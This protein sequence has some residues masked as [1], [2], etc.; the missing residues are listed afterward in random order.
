MA[1]VVVALFI[2]RS[3][4]QPGPQAD[5]SAATT[6]APGADPAAAEINAG[7]AA[8][9]PNQAV[10]HFK[11]ALEINPQHYGA[12]FQ[13]ARAL[14]KAGRKDEALAQWRQVLA[15]AEQSNDQPLVE[16]ARTRIAQ[17]SGGQ[18]PAAAGDPMAA[19]LEA[20]YGRKDPATA[21]A[22]FREVLGQNPDHYGATYQLATAL[23]QAGD[24]RGARPVWQKMLQMAEATQDAQTAEAARA[25]LAELEK[26]LGPEAPPDPDAAEMNAGLEALYT[27]KDPAKAVTHFRKVLS[28]NAKHY[29][30]IFQLATA[31]DQAKK[32]F[33]ARAQWE[34][35]LEMAE[36]IQDA[37]TADAAR[38]RLAQRP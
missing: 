2:G 38:A 37:K 15:L 32:P 5:P 16:A 26:A 3:C 22:R 9:S 35:V 27:A 36:A 23:Q 11:K 6:A 1:C 17:G 4:S 8:Q 20:L 29:G 21:I 24:A 28:K 30:A 7:L 12:T 19:G 31:L 34:K 14:D 25:R 10:V 18:A 33:E 13:L